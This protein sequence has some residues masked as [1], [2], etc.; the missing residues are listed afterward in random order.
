M[1]EFPIKFDTTYTL[2]TEKYSPSFIFALVRPRCP[3]AN[4]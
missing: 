4:L 1:E 2:Y 3:R